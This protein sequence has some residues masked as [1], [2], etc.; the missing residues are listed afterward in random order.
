[1][2]EH[3]QNFSFLKGQIEGSLTDC[4]GHLTSKPNISILGEKKDLLHMC[5]KAEERS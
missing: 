4:V 1:M 3:C 5:L 2:K